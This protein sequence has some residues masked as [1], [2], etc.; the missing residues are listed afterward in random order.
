VAN[1]T[2]LTIGAITYELLDCFDNNLVFCKGI[3]RQYSSEFAVPGNKIGPTLNIRLPAQ[4]R[5]TSGP[6]LQ[7]QDYEEQFVP[8]TIDQKDHIYLYINSFEITLS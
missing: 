8:L 1:N 5:T 7:A 2:L 3:M 4:L 6:N